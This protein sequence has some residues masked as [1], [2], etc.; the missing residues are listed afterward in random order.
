M[1]ITIG[2]YLVITVGRRVS[3]WD[4]G[5]TTHR[6]VGTFNTMREAMAVVRA[7]RGI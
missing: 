4:T 7:R 6:L 2:N 5:D 1:R 3:I